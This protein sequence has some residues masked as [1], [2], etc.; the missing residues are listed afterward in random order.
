M[1]A[2]LNFTLLHEPYHGVHHWRS[3]LP[4]PELPEHVAALE[5]NAEHEGPPFRTFRAAVYDLL[6]SLADPRVGAQWL[7]VARPTRQELARRGLN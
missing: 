7:G 5:P 4:H 6:I 3:G 1:A 2:F